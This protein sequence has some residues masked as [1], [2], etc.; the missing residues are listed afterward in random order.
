MGL[1]N[2]GAVPGTPER[3]H[4]LLEFCPFSSRMIQW[5]LP[6]L[7]VVCYYASSLLICRSHHICHIWCSQLTHYNTIIHGGDVFP[8][9]I[10]VTAF[11]VLHFV[12]TFFRQWYF[13]GVSRV[14]FCTVFSVTETA[15]FRFLI[16]RQTRICP[17][18]PV[19]LAYFLRKPSLLQLSNK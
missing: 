4:C 17:I 9:S 15:I 1:P 10:T 11:S 6:F 2:F 8:L 12:S 3:P 14:L 13:L 19:S 7:L 18:N 5:L 16:S